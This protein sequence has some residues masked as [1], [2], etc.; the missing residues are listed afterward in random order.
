[1]RDSVFD[2]AFSRTVAIEGGFTADAKDR[3][4]WT[5]GK[6]GIGVLKGTKFGV[7]A[8]SYHDIDIVN[9][10][11][12][13]A[14]EI[15]RRDWWE[16]FGLERFGKAAAFQLFDAGMNHGMFRA[17]QM[18]Q[19]ALGVN[20]DGV[21]GEETLFALRWTSDKHDLLLRFLAERIEY[22]VNAESW[23]HYSR[24]WM[25]RVAKNLRYVAE[26]N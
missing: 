9:L 11:I 18:F 26:D 20:D 2:Q 1:M 13:E 5:G 10:T 14:K 16:K 12:E 25:R 6:V 15:Y 4:N 8:A 23:D 21:I 19:R 24:G 22:F 17:N 7:S 3:G